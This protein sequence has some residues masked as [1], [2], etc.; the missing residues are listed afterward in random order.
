[1]N[2]SKAKHNVF[3]LVL[4]G[5][6]L[7]AMP[8]AAQLSSGMITGVVHDSQGAVVPGATVTLINQAQGATFRQ[9]ETGPEGSFV[10]TPVPPGTYTL[11]VEKA[12]FKKYTRS[13]L[14]LNAADRLGLPPIVLEIGSVGES[15]TV[16]ASAV[17]LQTVSAERS[18]V[19]TG[20]QVLNLASFGRNYSDLLKTVPGFNAD[21]QNA[22]G[23]RSDQNATAVDGVL[24]FDTGCNCTGTWRVNIDTIAEFKVLTNGQQAEYGRAAGANITVVT[25]GGT[26]EFHGGGYTFIR[27]EWMNANTFQNNYNGLPRPRARYRTQGFNLGGPIYVPGKFNSNREKLFFFTNFEWQRPRVFDALT[28]LTVP[29]EKERVGDFSA[30]QENGR[31]VTI[32]DP[33]TGQPFAGNIIPQNMWNQYGREILNWFPTPNATGDNAYNYQYQFESKQTM[34]DRNFRIDYNISNNWKFF[35]RLIQNSRLWKQAGG[36]NINNQIGVSPFILDWGAISGSG[37][38][39]TILT[40]TMTNELNYG[41]SRNFLPVKVPSD[42]K[43]LR[44]NAGI[45]LP[46]LYPDADVLG[47]MP[48]LL[49]DVPNSPNIYFSGLPYDNENPTWNLT[50]NLAKVFT[51]HTMKVGLYMES[52]FKRQTA[53]EVNNGRLYFNRD[54]ANPGDTG[55]AFANALIGSYQSFDQANVY[56]KGYYRYNTVEWFAQDNWRVRPDLTL[57]YGIRFS[58]IQPMYDE[59]DQISSFVPETWDPAKKVTLFRPALVNGARVAL[60][61]LTGQTAPAVLIGAIVPNSGDPF[62]GMQQAGQNGFPRGLIESRGVQYGPRFG[63]AWMPTGPGGKTV[64]RLGGGVFYERIQGNMVY[65]QIIFPPGLV[66]PKMY[67]GN[68]STIASSSGVLY[69]LTAAGLSRDGKLPTV[70]NYNL[71]IQRELPFGL[72]LD[73]GYVGTQSRHLT[74]RRPFN[75]APFGSAWLPENQDPTKPATLSGDSALPVD[76]LRPYVGYIGTGATVAQSGLG[77]G[78]FIA[79]YGGSSNYNALQISLNRRVGK[80]L[81][82]GANYTWGKAL[83]TLS[84]YDGL[85]H[86]L[87]NRKA[88]YGPLTFDRTQTLNINYIYN[89]PAVIR[90]GSALNNAVLRN[91]LNDWQISG[92]TSL[93]S[94]GPL[95]WSAQ[96]YLIQGVGGSVLN[97]RITGSEGWAPRP[98]LTCNPNL[99]P[100]DRTLLAWIGTGCFQPAA[101]GSVGMDSPARPVR[102]PGINNWDISLFKNFRLGSNEQRYIQLRLETYNTWNHTQASGINLTPQ[103]D[104]TGKLVNLAGAGGGRWGFGAVNAFRTPRY[105]QIAARIYF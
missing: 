62:N 48:S 99:N 11:T 38:L 83:G 29:T 3:L 79:T 77:S 35:F 24:V 70:Y 98:V 60:N 88:N 105:I 92:I 40:P 65:N 89:L 46:L 91:L 6:V 34:E 101:K 9:L 4:A 64:I 44:K 36:L 57:D 45:T 74:G 10:I 33:T 20:N 47:L 37:N 56:R 81:Q 25:K 1:M 8:V 30:T 19:I 49:W 31:P 41:N 26:R 32:K 97:K 23:L 7:A 13:D 78:G 16:E 22:N 66:T 58:V 5:L 93:S 61:P 54:S 55:W 84:S 71:S 68:L 17:T 51:N 73:V 94:G 15:I 50:D 53:T 28:F 67:Y 39:T 12:G 14:V 96:P 63:L 21:T 103:F 104:S 75:E 18:G 86:P 42:S 2:V 80:D 90:E 72:L 43:Y 102:G 87:D 27:N 85:E 69:P 82:F 95:T 76:F 100:G 52:S 59:K